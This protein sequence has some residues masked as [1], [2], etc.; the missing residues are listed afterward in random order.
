MHLKCPV[1]GTH[2]GDSRLSPSLSSPH[3]GGR[4]RWDPHQGE[5]LVEL[6]EK[7]GKGPARAR[8]GGRTQNPASISILTDGMVVFVQRGGIGGPWHPVSCVC[9]SASGEAVF[10][11]W[12]CCLASRLSPLAFPCLAGHWGMV[13][14]WARFDHHIALMVWAAVFSQRK[15]RPSH[16]PYGFLQNFRTHDRNQILPLLSLWRVMPLVKRKDCLEH[17]QTG[18]RG[19]GEG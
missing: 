7:G 16:T 11:A 1:L 4:V 2:C 14:A 19:G 3:S 10:P 18:L 5:F 13:G 12:L 9:S 17:W 15:C 6:G 8:W